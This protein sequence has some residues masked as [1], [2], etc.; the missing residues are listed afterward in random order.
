[1]SVAGIVGGLGAIVSSGF[2][3]KYI[4]KLKKVTGVVIKIVHQGGDVIREF[5]DDVDPTNK[6]L[7]LAKKI[8]FGDASP[9]NIAN[10]EA[11]AKASIVAIKE[12]EEDYAELKKLYALKG[13]LIA[14]LK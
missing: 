8:K 7:A 11:F 2:G 10:L 9:E 3:V 1:M 13:E 6:A 5:R 12:Y 4:L 14:A